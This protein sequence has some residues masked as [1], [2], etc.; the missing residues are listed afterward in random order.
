MLS[1]D[2]WSS[3]NDTPSPKLADRSQSFRKIFT[4]LDGSDRPIG[5]IETGC[6]RQQDNWAGDRFAEFHP[7]WTVYSV[8]CNPQATALCRSLVSDRVSAAA[9]GLTKLFWS[10]TPMKEDGESSTTTSVLEDSSGAIAASF[11]R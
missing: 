11:F 5:V 2:F 6:V 1:P 8:D 7:G 3:F 10:G 4:Y 9:G